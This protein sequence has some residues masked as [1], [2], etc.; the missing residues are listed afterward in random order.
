MH[1]R[2]GH[3]SPHT[4]VVREGG[5]HHQNVPHELIIRIE[6]RHIIEDDQ[7]IE[8]RDG[9]EKK[10]FRYSRDHWSLLKEPPMLN[11]R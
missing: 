9:N 5:I 7:A 10:Q 4:A 6:V 2:I 8:G 1:D 11:L 3:R